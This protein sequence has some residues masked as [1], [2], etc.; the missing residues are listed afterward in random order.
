MPPQKRRAKV[1]PFQRPAIEMGRHGR[2]WQTLKASELQVG[3]I[4]E[5][6]GL[7]QTVDDRS[8]WLQI[9]VDMLNGEHYTF[10]VDDEVKAFSKKQP[11][12]KTGE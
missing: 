1:P 3:D 5:G 2:T 7:V 9:D 12:T 4:V 6:K 8:E 10:G 11:L